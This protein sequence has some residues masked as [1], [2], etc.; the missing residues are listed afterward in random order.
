MGGLQV[1]EG[2]EGGRVRFL[3]LGEVI[4]RLRRIM[5]AFLRRI[6]AAGWLERRYWL[7]WYVR[8]RYG[9]FGWLL[10]HVGR[11][12]RLL[13]R[14]RMLGIRAPAACRLDSCSL[15]SGNGC[16]VALRRL[17][18][19]IRGKGVGGGMLRV[20]LRLGIVYGQLPGKPVILPG[21]RRPLAFVILGGT[22]RVHR[23]RSRGVA[24]TARATTA[25]YLQD[26]D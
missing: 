5:G 9:T 10:L 23:R 25:I 2:D 15:R 22:S 19:P 12:A 6:S 14:G 1:V 7:G 21:I 16:R 20:R 18:L 3:G 4:G 17:F 24:E 11:I 26:R 13:R 8:V